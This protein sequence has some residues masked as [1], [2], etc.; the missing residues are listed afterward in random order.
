MNRINL[1]PV[2]LKKEIEL[3]KKNAKISENLWRL[4]AVF[5]VMLG[6]LLMVGTLVI[7]KEMINS[8][9]KAA[10]VAELSDWAGTEK[11]AKDFASRLATISGIE[12]KA[13]DWSKVLNEVSKATP[14][15][16]RLK[17]ADFT[18]NGTKR[19][20]FEGVALSDKDVVTFRELL[21]KSSIFEYVDIEKISSG[22]DSSNGNS[23]VR[24]FTITANMKA[25]EVKK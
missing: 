11:D 14:S 18:G 9:G 15:N 19:I 5:F 2:E 25:N 4:L 12:S 17:A 22:I 20:T 16:V 8:A 1:L 13:V 3:S 24:S 10:V 23:R 6:L 21:S 7:S